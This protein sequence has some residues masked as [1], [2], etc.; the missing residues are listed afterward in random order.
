MNR[1]EIF[2]PSGLLSFRA[3]AFADMLSGVVN[4]GAVESI[5]CGLTLLLL[6]IL[7]QHSINLLQYW[8]DNYS[9]KVSCTEFAT[10]SADC[11]RG[12]P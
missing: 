7:L 11:V 6:L 5:P 1:A 9:Y 12:K 10:L 3:R 8:E 2:V 4:D